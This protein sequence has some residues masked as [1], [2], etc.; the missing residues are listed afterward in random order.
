MATLSTPKAQ[1]SYVHFTTQP[2]VWSTFEI[3]ADVPQEA[4]GSVTGS[5]EWK[6]SGEEQKN[7]GISEMQEAGKLREQDS[8]QHGLGSVEKIAGQAVGCEGMEKE[9]AKSEKTS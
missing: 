7:A 4:V 5:E 3:E 9:G 1:Q 2:S 8:T 6:K